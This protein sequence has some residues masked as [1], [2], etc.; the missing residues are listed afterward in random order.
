MA[1]Q[2]V[3]APKIAQRELQGLAIKF[4]ATRAGNEDLEGLLRYVVLRA[5]LQISSRWLAHIHMLSL[6]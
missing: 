4:I 5:W 2:R 3:H 6:L 1:P